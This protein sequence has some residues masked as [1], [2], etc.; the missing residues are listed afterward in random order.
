MADRLPHILAGCLD[1]LA[2]EGSADKFFG[3]ESDGKNQSEDNSA[4]K[5]G[6]L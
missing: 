2:I 6:K 3:A 5:N 4:K 1:G